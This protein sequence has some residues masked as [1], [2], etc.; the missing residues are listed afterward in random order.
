MRR[1]MSW[2][3]FW[4]A[5][6][7][8]LY[9]YIGFPLL[10]LARAFL[11]PRPVQRAEITPSLSL[12]IVAH[13]EAEFIVKKIDNALAQDYPREKIEIIVA[14][15]G[16]TDGMNELVAAYDEPEVRL[17]AFPRAG[18]N[19]TLNK[20]VAAARGEILVFTDADSMMIPNTLR[21]IA[22]PFADPEI[23]GVCGDYRY[24]KKAVEGAGERTYWNY[25]RILKQLQTQAGNV[26]SA[27]GQL[28]AIRRSLF[29]PVV[30]GVTDDFYT[31]V[32]VTMAHKRLIFEPTAVVHGPVAASEGAEFNRKVRIMTRGLNSVWQS[33]RLL[34]PFEYG[35]Y[36]IQVFSHKLLRRLI[37]IPLIMLALSA[38]LLWGRGWLYKLAT[39]GQTGLHGLALGGFLLRNTRVGRLKFFSL[40][41]FFDMVYTASVFAIINFFR[42]KRQDVWIT[43]RATTE[44]ATRP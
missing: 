12:I 13:N 40:P 26:T 8:I 22:A 3:V 10:L 30:S 9:T 24:P 32:R 2:W 33:R 11:R 15:D 28:Y 39:I 19:P 41:F 7:V 42:G 14:S 23:G 29:Q 17:L 5:V 27:S 38:P 21:N 20:A 6:G 35:F 1:T 16:S 31:S 36:A 34:N 4:S 18:K 44:E 25:D 37:A 43:E